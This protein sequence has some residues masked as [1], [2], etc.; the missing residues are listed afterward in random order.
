MPLATYTIV[1]SYIGYQDQQIAVTLA[2]GEARR[3]DIE[4]V[5]SDVFIN[6][7]VVT[8]EQELE[9]EIRQIGVAQI[10]TDVIKKL[11][12]LLEP[13]VFRSLQLLP[14]V[15]AASDYSSGLYI[16]GGSPDQTLIL[17]DRTTVYNPSHFFGLFSNF[18]PDAIK[19]V[20]LYKGGYPAAYGG[21]LGSV[22]DIYNKDGNRRDTQGSLSLGLLASRA[23][24]EGPYSKGSWMFAARRST[25]EPLLAALNNADIDGIPESF[26][27][28]DLNGKVNFDAN[29][30]NRFS[31]AAYAGADKLLFP[32]ADDANINL[33]YGNQTI[34]AN[35]T[36]IFS[37]RLFSN[38]TTTA[39]PILQYT[40]VRNRWY[41]VQAGEY[42]S[43]LFDQGRL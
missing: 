25:L 29:L 35:W 5:P 20:R 6:E 36:H 1:C 8:A 9:E 15:K 43:R 41:P 21:R 7:V 2:S 27:F 23:L 37:Q 30:N 26:Y 31:L 13:D 38:F 28:Y 33:N 39:S 12:T 3:L 19:D 24:V 40:R 11:P 14:G 16:R 4:L 34:S 18:N 42:H 32:F 10:K 22:V 17:L